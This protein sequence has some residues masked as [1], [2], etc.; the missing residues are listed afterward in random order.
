MRG[1]GPVYR[2]G[3]KVMYPHHG[4]AVIE[5][6]VKRDMFGKQRTY[7]KLR[8]SHGNLTL[9]IPLESTEQ[10][11]LRGVASKGEVK[12]VFDVLREDEGWMPLLWSQRYK[13]NLAKLISGDIY[14]GAELVRDLSI[15]NRGKAL[16]AA[17][18][19]MLDKARQIL[20]SELTFAFDCTEEDAE[21]M[22]DTALAE[23][24]PGRG[25]ATGASPATSGVPG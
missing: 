20:V 1:K 21:A 4:A 13:T 12:K 14:Q 23:P 10:V 15:R 5:D 11:G 17:E 25:R 6:V 19:R 22:L 24:G 2:K 16:S 8:F 9:L 18:R 7:A 3:D